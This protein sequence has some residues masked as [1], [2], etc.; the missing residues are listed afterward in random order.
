[1]NRYFYHRSRQP[2]FIEARQIAASNMDC[3]PRVVRFS[4]ANDGKRDAIS[5]R[6][7]TSA[8]TQVLSWY[9]YYP[10]SPRISVIGFA[11]AQPDGTRTVLLCAF[12]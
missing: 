3:S 7:R 6:H 4:V 5:Y 9:K 10:E 1:L 2:L 8:E 12:T 11:S